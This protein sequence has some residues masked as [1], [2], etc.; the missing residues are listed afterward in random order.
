MSEF[1]RNKNYYRYTFSNFEQHT[2]SPPE[3]H[4][5]AYRKMLNILEGPGYQ[6]GKRERTFDGFGWH[7]SLRMSF[8]GPAHYRSYLKEHGIVEASLCDRP[9]DKD[10]EPPI[11]TEELI[12]KAIAAYGIP[13]GGV[14]AEALLKGE[15]Q[16]PDEHSQF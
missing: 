7:D 15:A 3:A 5:Y 10:F 4:K 12:R 9:Q 8:R 13:I 14:L 11:W 1:D 16:W 6:S 2:M